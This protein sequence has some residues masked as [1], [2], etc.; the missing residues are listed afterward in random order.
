MKMRMGNRSTSHRADRSPLE[1]KMVRYGRDC[2]PAFVRYPC[3]AVR[4]DTLA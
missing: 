1:I 2:G 3:G 4:L